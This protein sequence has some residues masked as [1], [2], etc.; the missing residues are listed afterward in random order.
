MA[1]VKKFHS[2]NKTLPPQ[3][4]PTRFLLSWHY[5]RGLLRAR[6]KI[7]K[8]LRRNN[9]QPLSSVYSVTG[10]KMKIVLMIDDTAAYWHLSMVSIIS[11]SPTSTHC[12]DDQPIVY[13]HILTALTISQSY[14][15]TFWLCWRSAN[16]ISIHSDCS[17]DQPIVYRNIP[18]VQ[19]ISQ[20]NSDTVWLSANRGDLQRKRSFHE[21]RG[22]L[23]NNLRKIWYKM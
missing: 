22:S 2:I 9:F 12:S 14:I 6:K 18:A 16:R 1:I 15:D 20:L 23:L 21:R 8:R 19:T 10:W 5:Y 11:L 17:Y 3:R 13:R 4:H 7:R